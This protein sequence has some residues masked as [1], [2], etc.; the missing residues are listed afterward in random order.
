MAGRV[1]AAAVDALL[2]EDAGPLAPADLLAAIYGNRRGTE[3]WLAILGTALECAS[4][5]C[6]AEE[7]ASAIA[8][9]HETSLELA[10]AIVGALDEDRGVAA[11]AARARLRCHLWSLA[12]GGGKIDRA[13]L[14]IAIRTAQQYLGWAGGPTA[15]ELEA[16]VKAAAKA[17]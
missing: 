9:Q 3:L 13:E 12:T 16:A 1:D 14:E 2:G 7:T 15:R 11:E 10:R 17:R 5:Q 6:D 4:A 8:S